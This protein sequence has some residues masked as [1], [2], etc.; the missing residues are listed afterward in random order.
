MASINHQSSSWKP[1]FRGWCDF[2]E[3]FWSEFFSK[4]E[5]K[6][7]KKDW[8]AF[9]FGFLF[10]NRGFERRGHFEHQG[11]SQMKKQ[12]LDNTPSY[13]FRHVIMKFIDDGLNINDMFADVFRALI[14]YPRFQY[15][16]FA[17]DLFVE[18]LAFFKD[19]L[20]VVDGSRF[21]YFVTKK[22]FSFFQT[23]TVDSF[24]HHAESCEFAAKLLEIFWEKLSPQFRKE[25]R[26]KTK[27]F[28]VSHVE[29]QND[30]WWFCDCDDDDC[31]EDEDEDVD[32]YW[33]HTKFCVPQ[34]RED[35]F[36]VPE[37]SVVDI[38]DEIQILEDTVS[39][40][41]NL[42]KVKEKLEILAKEL[43]C[44]VCLVNKVQILTL[45]CKHIVTCGECCSKLSEEKCPLCRTEIEDKIAARLP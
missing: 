21:F 29:N 1:V 20:T 13:N 18:D 9:V 10:D 15:P 35:E 30:V 28:D 14:E 37:S 6:W 44:V 39:E 23:E 2:G 36:E 7:K 19:K 34:L 8:N 17:E 31:E 41:M 3:Q 4:T 5:P 24:K 16:K 45:P 26:E 32:A 43:T 40:D 12:F 25:L 42:K 33:I 27:D 11:R 38:S 22:T